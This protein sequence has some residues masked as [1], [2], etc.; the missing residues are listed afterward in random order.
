MKRF[1]FYILF[2]FLTCSLYAC[3]SGEEPEQKPEEPEQPEVE[4]NEELEYWT[5]EANKSTIAFVKHF[6]NK[7]RKYFNNIMNQD[8]PEDDWGVLATGSR[9]GYRYRRLCSY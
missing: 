6:W 9:H 8:T 4:V 5:K 1:L 3:S 2:A 7:D